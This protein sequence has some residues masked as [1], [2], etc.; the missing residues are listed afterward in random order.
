MYPREPLYMLDG[1]AEPF[2]SEALPAEELEYEPSQRM[3]RTRKYS[4]G[5]ITPC[6]GSIG[7]GITS[8]S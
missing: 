4:D 1:G 3:P 6:W 7:P 8:S 5:S 2:R